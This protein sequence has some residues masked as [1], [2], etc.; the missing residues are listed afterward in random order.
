MKSIFRPIS[1]LSLAL[2]FLLSSCS[3]VTINKEKLK[4]IKKVAIVGFGVFKTIDDVITMVSDST[5]SAKEKENLT[6]KFY[7]ALGMRISQ[8]LNWKVVPHKD[9][10][11]N[12]LYQE[13][14]Q[15]Y[16][17]ESKMRLMMGNPLELSNV[18]IPP[19]F[20][21]MTAIERKQLCKE[22][23]VD[24]IINFDAIAYAGMSFGVGP[25]KFTK[26][27][28]NVDRFEVFNREDDKS[29]VEFTDIIGSTP[30]TDTWKAHYMGFNFNGEDE[31]GML[32]AVSVVADEITSEIKKR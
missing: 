10:K 21:A 18:M 4:G 20:S 16:N 7:T 28:V 19:G 32:G 25:L 2:M 5:L 17:G 8:N 23:G 27:R 3:S 11:S 1:I 31:V 14:Y 9:F 29:I 22:L 24:A 15:K 26:Y 6:L 13:L 12:K 30:E